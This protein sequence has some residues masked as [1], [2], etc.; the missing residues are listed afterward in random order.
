VSIREITP[1]AIEA[2]N[3]ELP[4]RMLVALL[5][6]LASPIDTYL[7]EPVLLPLPVGM[8]PAGILN[9]RTNIEAKIVDKFRHLCLSKTQS[10]SA[11]GD[12]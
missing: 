2:T 10:N 3:Q 12:I 7:L 5:L 9:R 11:N 6:I 4:D 8:I 1:A